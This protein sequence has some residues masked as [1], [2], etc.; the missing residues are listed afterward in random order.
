MYPYRGVKTYTI[1]IKENGYKFIS[2][3]QKEKQ[4]NTLSDQIAHINSFR[5]K[6]LL[7]YLGLELLKMHSKGILKNTPYLKA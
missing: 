3:T 6:A 5:D 7:N 4:G 2:V 1:L